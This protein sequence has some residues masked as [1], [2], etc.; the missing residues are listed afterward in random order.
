MVHSI[1]N[2][3]LNGQVFSKDQFLLESETS[4]G[5]RFAVAENLASK[6]LKLT[7]LFEKQ[8]FSLG[9]RDPIRNDRGFNIDLEID[10]ALEY[11]I[12]HVPLLLK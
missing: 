3:K 12:E 4:E 9:E 8:I 7:D 5:I 10:V 1:S 2:R 6:A 11:P